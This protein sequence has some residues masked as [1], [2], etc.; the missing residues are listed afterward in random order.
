MDMTGQHSTSDRRNPAVAGPRSE[1]HATGGQVPHSP[2]QHKRV[3]SPLDDIGLLR[4]RGRKNARGCSAELARAA[5]WPITQSRPPCLQREHL[6]AWRK[7]CNSHQTSGNT[8]QR[9]TIIGQSSFSVPALNRR[10]A[11]EAATFKPRSIMCPAKIQ[12]PISIS[13][14]S[15]KSSITF[16][17]PLPAVTAAL[18]EISV[19]T[20]QSVASNSPQEC[21]ADG[22]RAVRRI[23]T[24]YLYTWDSVHLPHHR[25]QHRI[26]FRR[27]C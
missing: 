7:K 6:I 24:E 17:G 19:V 14:N 27:V 1:I 25:E 21:L 12:A 26:A 4:D 8:H 23:G 13:C 15:S 20:V 22:R 16:E 18:T 5:A 11:R 2:R 3:P 9:R 10:V